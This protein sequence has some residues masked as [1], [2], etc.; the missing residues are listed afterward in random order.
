M[1]RMRKLW[2]TSC[3]STIGLW[4]EWWDA[5]IYRIFLISSGKMVFWLV[6]WLPSILF[7]HELI[8]L[9][10]SSQLT[11][12]HIFQRGGPTTTKQLWISMD[13]VDG[14]RIHLV[15]RCFILMFLL[16]FNHAFWWP[17]PCWCIHDFMVSCD[18]KM[19]GFFPRRDGHINGDMN[20]FTS[21]T[22][23]ILW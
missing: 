23:H 2:S 17:W 21:Y 12:K 16:G 19:R 20:I 1:G 15:D 6:V 7:S 4:W 9:L 18:V 8:G 10:S 22:N 5:G 11:K 14:K 3:G 13:T